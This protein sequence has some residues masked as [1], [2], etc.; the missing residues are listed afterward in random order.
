[1]R[2]TGRTVADIA[3]TLGI[4]PEFD[5]RRLAEEMTAGFKQAGT[6]AGIDYNESL[7][8]EIDKLPP[9]VGRA[10]RKT[11][12]AFNQVDEAS[13]KVAIRLEEQTRLTEAAT[14]AGDR[15]ARI[16]ADVAASESEKAR[17]LQEYIDL[18]RAERDSTRA[19]ITERARLNRANQATAS[20]LSAVN[21]ALFDFDLKDGGQ[22]LL[23]IGKYIS[24]LRAAAIPILAGTAAVTGSA[25]ISS[26]AALS[27]ALWTVPAAGA[28]AASGIGT[29][30]LATLGFSDAVENM[31][32]EKKFYEAIQNLSPNAQ[33]AALAIQALTEP[34]KQLK[35]NTQDALF[36]DFSPMINQLAQTYLPA[37]NQLTAGIADA[38]N[39]AA[40]G[41]FD[42]LMT[43]ET[44]TV[45]SET[46]DN[47]VEAFERL[48]PAAAPF[49]DALT[50]IIQTGSEFLPGFSD[51]I[52]GAAEDFAAFIRQAQESGDLKRWMQEGIDAVK[53]LW[54]IVK[55]L[56]KAFADLSPAG[57]DVLPKIKSIIEDTVPGVVKLIENLNKVLTPVAAIFDFFTKIFDVVSKIVG[58]LEG[59]GNFFRNLGPIGRFLFHR[60]G[61]GAFP[62][63]NM[64]SPIGG[65]FGWNGAPPSPGGLGQ[66]AGRGIT[67]GG[68][69]R[70]AGKG[71]KPFDV[72]PVPDGGYPLPP[73]PP[74]KGKKKKKDEPPFT[75]DPST[76]SLDSIPIGS[77]FDG[78]GN[79]TVPSASAAGAPLAAEAA[80]PV[81]AIPDITRANAQIDALAAIAAMPPFNLSVASDVRNEPGSWHNVAQAGDFSNSSGPTPEMHAFAMY[82]AQNFG[83]MIEELIYSDPIRG[84]V[85]IGGGRPVGP[86]TDQPGYYSPKT[87][88]EHMDHVHIAVTD[89]MAPYLEA[90]M[91]G[92]MLGGFGPGGYGDMGYSGYISVDQEKIAKA[93]AD[94]DQAARTVEEK[95]MAYLKLKQSG[96]ADELQ[97]LR[98]R[99]DVI[100][101]EQT[102]VERERAVSEARMGT[103]KEFDGKLKDSAKQVTASMGQI[104]TDLAGD[105]GISEGLPGIAKWLTQFLGNLAFA[106]MLGALSA[107]S[108]AG[109]TASNTRGA[110]GLIGM[111]APPAD[112][113]LGGLLG[114]NQQGG[115]ANL[116]APGAAAQPGAAAMGPTPLGGAVGLP[117][118]KYDDGGMM[119][120]GGMGINLTGK[121]EPVLT[122][123]QWSMVQAAMAPPPQPTHQGTGAPPGPTTTDGA[124][125]QTS[126]SASAAFGGGGFSGLGGLPMQGINS[127]ISAAGLA[128]DAL[129]PGAGQAASA[130]AQIGVQLA[131]RAIGYAGQLA[132]IGVGGIMDTFLPNNSPLADPNNSWFGRIASGFAGAR[133]ALP[134]TA[135]NPAPAQPQAAGAGA[136]QQPG[137][138]MVSVGAINNYTNDGG[139][140]VARQIGRMQM[141]S[142]ASGGPR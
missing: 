64:N 127:A 25:I 8:S 119:P 17:A 72:S 130:A 142:Y 92:N 7:S 33:Q 55:Q 26:V 38:M 23:T 102:L 105:F 98:A 16:N 104:G 15:Y 46:I 101:A 71:I 94:R 22:T 51:S 1:M 106:P 44:Q 35:N 6:K 139:Q 110:S 56:G 126:R 99:N 53:V 39:S 14:A 88:S 68:L 41:I 3:L 78:A 74:E 21:D 131:N 107:V 93:E 117:L 73:P 82:M 47:V 83:G 57:Q 67:R 89:A 69:G 140:S 84:N 121:P 112:N 97:M 11:A 70:S 49:A 103:Y 28:A 42:Q 81:M 137:G 132:G 2:R 37:I 87:L 100:D 95:R 34:L 40:R 122:P 48:A 90:A 5:S 96:D 18:Q 31:G 4:N 109:N 60:P 50:R 108:Q 128:L 133:P 29:L 79:V 61:D 113:M 59:I 65:P 10:M 45:L 36:A 141:S 54:D 43:P 111:F 52:T 86:G 27:Q 115:L 138:P 58:K 30:K 135:G 19:L 20:S 77:F 85:L 62:S 24:A 91:Q 129:A 120:S 134:N 114:N 75:A 63:V 118:M 124:T 66:S 13:A 32:D 76:Y 12:A 136:Q 80:A 116:F 125:A 9:K 123:D